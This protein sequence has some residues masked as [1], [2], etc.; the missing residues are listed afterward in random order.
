MSPYYEWNSNKMRPTELISTECNVAIVAVK[1]A[2]QHRSPFQ[3]LSN[4]APVS[5]PRT[6]PSPEPYSPLQRKS[7]QPEHGLTQGYQQVGKS[8]LVYSTHRPPSPPQS[9]LQH[10]D[11]TPSHTPSTARYIVS[12]SKTSYNVRRTLLS[13]QS[14]SRI[15]YHVENNSSFSRTFPV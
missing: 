13:A 7:W 5:R 4:A 11:I 1:T 6:H 3:K 2:H 12:C 15:K 10:G 14:V 9:P 8:G